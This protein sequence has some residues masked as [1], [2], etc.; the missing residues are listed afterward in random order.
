MELTSEAISQLAD[1]IR[2]QTLQTAQKLPVAHTVAAVSF[3]APPF[4]ASN[5]IAWLLRLRPHLP[6]THH[7]SQTT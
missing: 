2:Q 7:P 1:A 6:H 4:W 3:K 5:A